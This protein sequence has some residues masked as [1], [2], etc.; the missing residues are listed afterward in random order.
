VRASPPIQHELFP[1]LRPSPDEIIDRCNSFKPV[2][3]FALYSGGDDSLVTTHWLM[4]N[5]HCDEV[6]SID[7]GIGL[8]VTRRHIRTTCVHYGWPLV[9]VRAKEDCG[10]DY[11][12]MVLK[13]G[14]PGP[15]AHQLMYR[16]LKERAIEHIV[17]ERKRYRSREKV[18]L[19]T[20]I[21]S[22]ESQWRAGYGG[23]EVTVV[24]GAQLWANPFYHVS[25]QDFHEYRV[26]H[27][28]PRGPASILLG[29]SGE[30]LCGSYAEE[31]E[32]NGIRLI[33]PAT[34]DEIEQLEREAAARGHGWR[35]EQRP[36]APVVVDPRQGEA[37]RPLCM[38][39]A[40]MEARA[41]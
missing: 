21:R 18:L 3:R 28:L 39:C 22:D 5:G 24:K 6:L 16:N 23:Q 30:C 20:G 32:L 19:A 12:K 40:K 7:T 17:R 13:H 36:P 10:Q 1:V 14:F 25:G 4:T 31:G 15:P 38:G 29:M 11:R 27:S 9:E 2:A 33:E 8:K 37:F 34:A 35:W 26:E 41:A